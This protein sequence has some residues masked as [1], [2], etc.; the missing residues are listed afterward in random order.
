MKAM[1]TETVS[2]QCPSGLESELRRMKSYF[3][4]RIV[5]GYVGDDSKT[6]VHADYN[7]RGMNRV[8]RSG[9]AVFSI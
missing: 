9:K 3:P 8:V 7:K 5:W 1:N 6:H 2:T 4:F